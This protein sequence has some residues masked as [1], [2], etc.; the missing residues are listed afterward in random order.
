MEDPLAPFAD[1]VEDDTD[2]VQACILLFFFLSLVTSLLPPLS[3]M[4]VNYSYV[5]AG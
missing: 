3:E 1:L 5:L 2:A 4:W